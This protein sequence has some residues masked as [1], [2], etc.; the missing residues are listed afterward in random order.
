MEGEKHSTQLLMRTRPSIKVA[1]I[2]AAAVENRSVSSL[3]ETILLEW[4]RAKGYL[5]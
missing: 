3:V 1:L 2:R 4:L 5:K